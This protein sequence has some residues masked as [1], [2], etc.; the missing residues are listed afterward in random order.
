VANVLSPAP[1][2]KAFDNNGKPMNGGRLFTYA[3]L[4]STKIATYGTSD[5]STLNSNPVVLDFR[6]EASVWTLPNTAYKFVLAPPGSDDP[7]TN[8]IWSV[9]NI[10]NSV[11]LTLYGGTDTGSVNAYVLNFSAPFTA[12]S[13]GIVIYWLPANT[14][15]GAST[16]N[17][18]GLGALAIVDQNGNPLIAGAIVSNQVTGV[19]LSGGQ[20]RLMT[21]SAGSAG[22]FTGTLTGMVGATTGTVTYRVGTNGVVSLLVASDIFGTSNSTAMTMTGLPAVVRPGTAAAVVA[23]P[24]VRDNGNTGMDAIAVVDN[25]GVIEFRIAKTNAIANYVQFLAA[26]FTNAGSK[27]IPGGWVLTYQKWS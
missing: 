5:L 1:K 20:W 15:T 6:G 25:S 14:N 3:A 24:F 12:Y 16:L 11:L 9:D 22:T 4:S 26:G 8:P 13:D 17:V 27:G 19:I 23:S 7:P 18:N 21:V 10:V 2:F